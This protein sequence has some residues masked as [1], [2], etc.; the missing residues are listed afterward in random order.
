MSN[1]NTYRVIEPD[2]KVFTDPTS[3]NLF[4]VIIARL[5]ARTVHGSVQLAI[6]ADGAGWYLCVCGNEP[7]EGDFPTCDSAGNEVDLFS[8]EWDHKHVVCTQC[9]R[10]FDLDTY[11]TTTDTIAVVG[12]CTTLSTQE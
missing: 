2:G 8:N 12:S 4:P 5:Y 6:Q 9:G 11:D 1:I 3:F 7:D 10:I